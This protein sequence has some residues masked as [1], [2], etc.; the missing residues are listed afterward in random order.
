[1]GQ[2]LRRAGRREGQ[3]ACAA[4]RGEKGRRLADRVPDQDLAKES[5]TRESPPLALEKKEEGAVSF[6]S[7]SR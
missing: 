4:R 3:V 2:G 1:M 6:W 5:E 7:K